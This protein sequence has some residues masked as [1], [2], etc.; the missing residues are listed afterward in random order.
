MAKKNLEKE[1]G[2]LLKEKYNNKPTKQ[3]YSDVKR[4][5]KGEPLDYVI[6]FTEFLGCKIDLS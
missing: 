2:W 3:F 5:E 1:I 4:L 6:G